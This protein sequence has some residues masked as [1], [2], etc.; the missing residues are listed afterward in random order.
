MPSILGR[1]GSFLRDAL[2]FLVTTLVGGAALYIVNLAPPEQQAAAW[3]FAKYLNEAQTQAEWAAATGYIPIRKSATELAPLTDRW[4]ELPE[5]RVAYDQL[6]D[7][8]END[9]TAGPV[10]GAYGKA[11]QGVRG[12]VIDAL[13]KVVTGDTSPADALAAAAEQANAAIKEYNSR[14]GA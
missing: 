10:I 1:V 13:E 14:V 8:A 4:A 9:A 7:G 5:L 6:L 3:T 2:I 11:G 12:A